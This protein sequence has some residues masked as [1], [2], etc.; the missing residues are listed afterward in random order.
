MNEQGIRRKRKRAMRKRKER[1]D[2]DG[3]EEKGERINVG[4]RWTREESEKIKRK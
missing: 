4:K 1:T 3:N 2:G